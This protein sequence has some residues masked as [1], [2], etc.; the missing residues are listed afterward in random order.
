MDRIANSATPRF[1]TSSALS[2]RIRAHL[3]VRSTF[4]MAKTPSKKSAKAV[5]TAAAGG[6]KKA[7]KTRVETY[8]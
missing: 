7:R 1:P 5:K 8:S 2:P 6:K 4:K 3:Q